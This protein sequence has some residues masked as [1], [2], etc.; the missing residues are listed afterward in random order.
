MIFKKLFNS[1]LIF[2]VFFV[3]A[4]IVMADI[5]KYEDMHAEQDG[6]CAGIWIFIGNVYYS[7]ESLC[8]EYIP[9][10][11]T[12][13]VFFQDQELLG[14][15]I[16][17]LAIDANDINKS[18]DLSNFKRGVNGC[19]YSAI[20]V[21]SWANS[22]IIN[23]AITHPLIMFLIDSGFLQRESH[24]IWP[25]KNFK[26]LVLVTDTRRRGVQENIIHEFFHVR[27]DLDFNFRKQIMTAWQILENDEKNKFLHERKSYN[28]SLMDQMIE[29][30]GIRAVEKKVQWIIGKD[31]RCRIDI[32]SLDVDKILIKKNK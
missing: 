8:R 11:K 20:Q 12:M 5:E 14:S 3:F 15:Y 31:K 23:G 18:V 2:I 29:E 30:W 6:S 7:T 13:C 21:A 22:N 26:H 19:H 10:P 24:W 9:P 27:Y 16:Y 17:E 32:M 4:S 25:T 28:V 1:I